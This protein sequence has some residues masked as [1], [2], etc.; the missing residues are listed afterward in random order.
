M[1]KENKLKQD[2]VT[3]KVSED[4]RKALRI[5]AAMTD[6]SIIDV[7]NRLTKAEL[8]KVE[9]GQGWQPV[10]LPEGTQCDTRMHLTRDQVAQLVVALQHWLEVTG[11]EPSRM[12]YQCEQ[13][14]TGDAYEDENKI[15]YCGA[16]WLGG[17]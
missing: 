9:A 12:C 11:D 4:A 17:G 1:A 13:D 3:I 6:E 14:I 8:A 7:V 5:I 2:A 10:T 16:C 15:Y